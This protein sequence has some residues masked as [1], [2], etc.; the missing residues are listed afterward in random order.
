[1]S[2]RINI[3]PSLYHLTDNQD[4]VVVNGTTVGQCLE[5]LIEMFPDMGGAL[6][7]NTGALLNYVDVYV[8]ME[9]AFPEQL[10]RR[11]KDGDELHLM[12]VI[13]GG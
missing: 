1:M 6:F 11:V 7:D 9:S 3:H 2:I 8:N 4:V 13:L 5:R 12:P 10:G